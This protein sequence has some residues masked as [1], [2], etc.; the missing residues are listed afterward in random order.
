MSAEFLNIKLEKAMI[1]HV[2]F[3]HLQPKVLPEP[4]YMAKPMLATECGSDIRS[5]S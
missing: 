2:C 1:Q 5:K 3:V 4:L